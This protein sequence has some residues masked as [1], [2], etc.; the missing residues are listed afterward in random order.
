MATNKRWG[1]D[2][3]AAYLW[4]TQKIQG[5]K[6]FDRDFLLTAIENIVEIRK[7]KGQIVAAP[8][9]I[10]KRKLRPMLER[11]FDEVLRTCQEGR[12]VVEV[13]PRMYALTQVGRDIIRDKQMA[14][15]KLD[16]K[17]GGWFRSC[18]NDTEPNY[19]QYEIR[20]RMGFSNIV[21]RMR[22]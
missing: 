7:A 18:L 22:R 9:A 11:P 10:L 4:F 13:A 14:V 8:Y 5:Y 16:W 20:I 1:S 17:L 3:W 2:K 6:H 12:T 19:A 21:K 15:S